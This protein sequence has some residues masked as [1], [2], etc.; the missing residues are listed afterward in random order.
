MLRSIYNHGARQVLLPTNPTKLFS[1]E[2]PAIL[3]KTA[4]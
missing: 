3:Q 1:F 2:V 4:A